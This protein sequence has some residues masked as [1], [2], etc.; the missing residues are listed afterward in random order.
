MKNIYVV[1]ND[2]KKIVVNEL[3]HVN[4]TFLPAEDERIEYRFFGLWKKLQ[5]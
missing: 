2:I 5:I 1:L 4:L 3:Q